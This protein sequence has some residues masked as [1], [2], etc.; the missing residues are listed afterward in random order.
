MRKHIIK[1]RT[2][3]AAHPKIRLLIGS[4]KLLLQSIA[5]TVFADAKETT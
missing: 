3:N 5:P 4:A 1:L 2:S